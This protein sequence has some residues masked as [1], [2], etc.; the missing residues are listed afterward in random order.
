MISTVPLHSPYPH[1]PRHILMLCAVTVLALGLIAIGVIALLAVRGRDVGIF[2]PLSSVGLDGACSLIAVGSILMSASMA[3]M[4]KKAYALSRK[5]PCDMEKHVHW[6][7]IFSHLDET[8]RALNTGSKAKPKG[9]FCTW[10]DPKDPNAQ[11]IC[12]LQGTERSIEVYHD[13]ECM[14]DRMTVLSDSGIRM[15]PEPPIYHGI[16]MD[17]VEKTWSSDPTDEDLKK[18]VACESEIMETFRSFLE[19]QENSTSHTHKIQ[20]AGYIFTMKAEGGK[21]SL[22]VLKPSLSKLTGPIN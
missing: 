13:T 10:S 4:I 9:S 22:H 14:M 18:F 11:F 8:E 7:T 16:N 21:L 2:R 15:A 19:D 6:N 17:T 5:M 1:R 12:V 3:L 20:H